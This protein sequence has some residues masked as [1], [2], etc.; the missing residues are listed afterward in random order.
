MTSMTVQ[1]FEYQK[2]L[3]KRY[4]EHSVVFWMCGTFYEVY[5]IYPGKDKVCNKLDVPKSINQQLCNL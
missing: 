4:G 1:Y 3:E 5:G 2:K